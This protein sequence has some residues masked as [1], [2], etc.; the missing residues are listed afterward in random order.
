MS[1]WLAAHSH[2][3]STTYSP[4]SE[5]TLFHRNANVWL[6]LHMGR[7]HVLAWQLLS[8]IIT[9]LCLSVP[10][11]FLPDFASCKT[12]SRREHSWQLWADLQ[13]HTALRQRRVAGLQIDCRAELK[14]CMLNGERTTV[15]SRLRI[16]G[17]PSS[18]LQ[19]DNATLK[20]CCH[21]Y[22]VSQ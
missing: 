7:S 3:T 14:L 21:N 5:V 11:A 4:F 8:K 15:G 22:Y 12:V 1:Q 13:A 19:T 10:G 18:W 9:T 2:Q 16:R 20:R 17:F 6:C